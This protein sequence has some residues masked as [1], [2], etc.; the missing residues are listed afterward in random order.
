MVIDSS[1]TACLDNLA[2]WYRHLVYRLPGGLPG[3]PC[4]NAMVAPTAAPTPTRAPT[5]IKMDRTRLC[6]AGATAAPAG[7]EAA[8]PV[9]SIDSA[10]AVPRGSCG[11]L[12]CPCGCCTADALD[13]C[14]GEMDAGVPLEAGSL[15]L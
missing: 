15:V 12:F 7:R 2:K 1:F 10:A 14:D 13:G 8:T 6:L 4:D 9:V 11:G 5:L 3:L